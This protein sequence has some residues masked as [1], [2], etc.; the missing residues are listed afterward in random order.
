MKWSEVRKL[1]PDK[2]IK[3]EV[4]NYDTMDNK[5]YVKDIAVI[6]VIDDSKIAM[7]EFSQCKEGQFVYSTKNEQIVIE[8]VK[9]I[10][11]RRSPQDVPAKV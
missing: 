3:F 9:Y 4:I 11:I 10:G 7:K 2:F 1:Y 8:V 5:R 6:D